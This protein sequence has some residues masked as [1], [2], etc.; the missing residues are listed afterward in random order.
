M[1]HDA[2]RV[3]SQL[4]MDRMEEERSKGSDSSLLKAEKAEEGKRPPSIMWN[5]VKHNLHECYF[6]LLIFVWCT[7]LLLGI[8]YISNPGR[9][10]RVIKFQHDDANVTSDRER[11]LLFVSGRILLDLLMLVR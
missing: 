10:E 8:L 7:P 5:I 3:M 6:S 9:T 4:R 11:V 1:K 2:R